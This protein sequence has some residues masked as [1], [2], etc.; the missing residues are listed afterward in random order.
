MGV[1]DGANLTLNFKVEVLQVCYRFTPCL[2]LVNTISS[3]NSQSLLLTKTAA[4]ISESPMGAEPAGPGP[5]LRL[6]SGPGS[7]SRYV[8]SESDNFQVGGDLPLAE[9]AQ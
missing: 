3:S 6:L 9:A 1:P 4:I 7:L 2:H 5:A 8:D